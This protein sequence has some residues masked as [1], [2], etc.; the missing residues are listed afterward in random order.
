MEAMN[1]YYRRS[2][3]TCEVE[4]FGRREELREIYQL[5]T[6]HQS[7][8]L[9][10]ERRTGKSSILN[11]IS[12][13][14]ATHSVPEH[15]RFVFLNCLYAEG[16]PERRFIRHMLGQ[17]SEELQIDPPPPERDSLWTVAD[18]ARQKSR[19]LVILMDEI[20][21]LV[22]NRAIPADLFSF[23]RAWSEAYRIPFV[24]A[25]REAKIERLLLGT[26]TS[27]SPFWNIFK[28]LY[29]GPFSRADALELITE[30]AR[31][32]NAPFTE[33]DIEW[34]SARGGRLPFFIQLAASCAFA[35]R[36]YD[37]ARR[38]VE[39]LS[40]ADQHFEYLIDFMPKPERVALVDILQGK[41]LEPRME[42]RLLQKGMLVED[43]GAPRLFS[44]ILADKLEAWARSTE[45]DAAASASVFNR[46]FR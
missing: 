21:V 46:F 20:D 27:G 16:S 17:I 15:V 23:F 41:T 45:A 40:E 24:I 2:A 28:S 35:H 30:P 6:Q 3:I 38:H 1:P 34:I 18:Q 9:I 10:G 4:F 19:Q 42:K 29:V 31:R 33:D 14:R 43:R 22:D 39:L 36:S 7:I 44:V 32:L 37:A 11:A 13:S 25:S 8:A 26:T 5:L 12:F